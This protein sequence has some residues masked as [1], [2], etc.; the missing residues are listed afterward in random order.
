MTTKCM[1]IK[2]LAFL[3]LLLP[4]LAAGDVKDLDVKDVDGKEIKAASGSGL[5]PL[6][7]GIRN[8]CVNN[9]HI[10]RVHFDSR[11]T[12]IM[13][14]NGKRKIKITLRNPCSGIRTEGYVHKPI[15]NQFCEGDILRVLNNGN[16]C[17]VGT[18]EPY[19]EDAK[20]E[21]NGSPDSSVK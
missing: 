20:P 15:N 9:M 6:E 8:G 14:L 19:V 10:K 5:N 3:A 17:V 1:T 4:P 13:E 12:G 18:L 11:T 7:W 2:R 21:D 16:A